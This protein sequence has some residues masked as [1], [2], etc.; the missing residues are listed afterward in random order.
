M[1]FEPTLPRKDR[2]SRMSFHPT[3]TPTSFRTSILFQANH[4]TSNNNT[5]TSRC[6]EYTD[7]RRI[8]REEPNQNANMASASTEQDLLP[9]QTEG[10]KVGE[11][12][13]MDEYNKLGTW[14]PFCL[15]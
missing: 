12:K 13:T 7:L 8:A 15:E 3:T 14:F 9:D 5:N 4:V 6:K 2:R 1:I 11:K 10:F